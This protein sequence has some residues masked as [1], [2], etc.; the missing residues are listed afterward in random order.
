[1]TE[2]P[3]TNRLLLAQGRDPARR[4][5][6]TLRWIHT[7]IGKTKV[8]LLTRVLDGRE[9]TLQQAVRFYEMR[10][11]IGESLAKGRTAFGRR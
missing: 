11:G 8:W 9:L 1:M 10:W 6:V 7:Q 2:G 3:G 5:A 4:S